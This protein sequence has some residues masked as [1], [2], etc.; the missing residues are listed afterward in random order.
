MIHYQL[1]IPE[2]PHPYFIIHDSCLLTNH[3]FSHRQIVKK[4]NP[5]ISKLKYDGFP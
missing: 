4:R 2:N 1:P 5:S 3:S